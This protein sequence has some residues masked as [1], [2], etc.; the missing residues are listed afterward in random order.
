MAELDRTIFLFLNSLNTPFLDSVMWFFSLKTVWIPMYIFIIYLLAVRYRKRIW[1]ILLFTVL[2]VL[3]TDQVSLFLKNHIGRLRPC[4]DPSL[5][6]L[7]HTVRGHCPGMYGFV[8][9]H[10]SN[11]FGLAAFTAPLLQK[12]WYTWSIFIW[13]TLV[14]YSRIYLG[15]HYP[16]DVIGGAMLGL[17]VGAGLAI[18]VTETDKRIG[19]WK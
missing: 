9:G 8:S 12:K 1:L 10:A 7:V 13:A 14:S 18:A 11:A 5:Q 19:L 16:G 15:V 4:H 6:G 17:I 3:I 2:L